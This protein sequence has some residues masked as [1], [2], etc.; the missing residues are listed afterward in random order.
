MAFAGGASETLYVVD[1][2][3]GSHHKVVFTKRIPALITFGAEQ[4][5]VVA[6]AV[7]LAVAH[8]ARAAL[9]EELTAL[10]ALQ[11]RRVPLEVRRDSQNVLVVNFERASNAK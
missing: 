7:G 10:L 11:A 3:F 8:E 1:F 5:N 9:V 2:G 4:T 6:L